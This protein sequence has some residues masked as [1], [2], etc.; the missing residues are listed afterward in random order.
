[1]QGI[2]T[3]KT[4]LDLLMEVDRE[5]AYS[6]L[7]LKKALQEK[8]FNTR[9]TAFI[10]GLFYGTLE[11]L[12]RIDYIIGLYAKNG[13]VH[14]VVRCALR[15]GIQQLLF[16]RVPAAAAIDTSVE[17]VRLAGKRQLCAFTNAVLRQVAANK[18]SIP[19]P[20]QAEDPAR[21]LSVMYSCPEDITEMWLGTY[22]FAFTQD[23]LAYRAAPGVSTV[24]ANLSKTT[25]PQLASDLMAQ[26]A[27]V[28][29]ARYYL[30]AFSVRDLGNIAENPLFLQ[31]QFSVMGEASM[32]AV[33]ALD[34]RP[35]QRIL[36]ACAAPGGKT[37]YIAE[38]M[39]NR[40]TLYA[41]DRHPHRV[42]LLRSTLLRMGF[43]DAEVDA[44][45]A[46]R[47]DPALEGALDAV[48]V[49]APCSGLGV[50]L[51]KPDI[52][53]NKCVEGIATLARVQG[54]LLDAVCGYLR[55]GG[56]L[57]YCTCTISR[58]ENEEVVTR[59]LQ[60]HPNFAPDSRGRFLPPGM[61]AGRIRNGCLQLFPHMDGTDG[62]FVAR[63][64]KRHG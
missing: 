28:E 23:M 56:V 12:L 55:P 35:G 26:G 33:H 9:D 27:R 1:M 4:A 43:G 11:N 24:R 16:M 30:N 58:A 64:V 57:V 51:G 62:F 6:N 8:A 25:A 53:L 39:G 59:F 34:P 37:A 41:W 50:M 20:D 18:D 60:R 49:D 2:E 19:Y 10:T 21:Y 3:R 32:L 17:L 36:D 22:G 45:D 47:P 38:L 54:A 63:L 29:R 52:R 48:L 40:G 13:R 44:R 31:G 61:D 42:R 46:T 5:G 7:A 15:L 14:R